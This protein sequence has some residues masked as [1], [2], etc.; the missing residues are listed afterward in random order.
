MPA[1]AQ[2]ISIGLH[3]GGNYCTAPLGMKKLQPDYSPL[4]LKDVSGKIAGVAGLRL[5]MDI[6][7]FQLGLSYE[8]AQLSY[9]WGQEYQ[10]YSYPNLNYYAKTGVRQLV[11]MANVKKQMRKSCLY[12]GINAGV[13]SIKAKNTKFDVKASP[14]TNAVYYQ[15]LEPGIF[16]PVNDSLGIQ[17]SK[18]D[19]SNINYPGTYTF[20][21]DMRPVFGLQVGYNYKLTKHFSL[22][23]ELSARYISGSIVTYIQSRLDW[24]I[25]LTTTKG[26]MHFPFTAGINYTF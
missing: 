26:I 23:G 3:G 25:E 8:H 18:P 11:F 22:N 6:K 24:P 10:V 15:S 20:T 9:T 21:K 17:T 5:L 14:Q 13:T 7:K 19:Y 1:S 16:N 12:F 4:L 2:K